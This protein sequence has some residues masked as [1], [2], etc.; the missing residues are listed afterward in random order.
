M[1]S[2]PEKKKPERTFLYEDV[3]SISDFKDFKDEI[4]VF[5]GVNVADYKQ[6]LFVIWCS[7]NSGFS[8]SHCQSTVRAIQS[9]ESYSYS[10]KMPF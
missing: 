2:H 8:C 6:K 7:E 10:S 3:K 4:I 1:N 9:H 5:H